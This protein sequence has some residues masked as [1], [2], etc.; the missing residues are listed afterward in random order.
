MLKIASLI[1]IVGI[2]LLAC[3]S[4]FN[5]AYGESCIKET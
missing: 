2:G 5:C 1:L 4:D 3:T